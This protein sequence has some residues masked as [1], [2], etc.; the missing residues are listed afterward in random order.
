MVGTAWSGTL[1]TIVLAVKSDANERMAAQMSEYEAKRQQRMQANKAKLQQLGILLEKKAPVKRVLKRVQST[2]PPRRSAR[3]KREPP[4]HLSKAEFVK[5]EDKNTRKDPPPVRTRKPE[6]E[7]ENLD[8]MLLKKGLWISS[9]F[10]PVQPETFHDRWLH[11]QIWPKGKYPVVQGM[12]PDHAPRFPKLSGMVRW[13]NAM[14]LFVNMPQEESDQVAAWSTYDNVF[15]HQKVG[16]QS[17]VFF[18]WFAPNNMSAQAPTVLRLLQA[19]RGVPELRI[20]D[21]MEPAEDVK[22]EPTDIDGSALDQVKEEIKVEAD[23]SQTEKTHLPVYLFIRHIE[24]RC[25]EGVRTPT[26]RL[27]VSFADA[28]PLHLL[29]PFG[30]SG[31]SHAG[32]ANRVPLADAGCG[33]SAMGPNQVARPCRWRARGVCGCG[34]RSRSALRQQQVDHSIIIYCYMGSLSLRRISCAWL[35]REQRTT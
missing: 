19:Q 4:L 11:R 30:L 1:R 31:P 20:G 15:Q 8:E 25:H 34:G 12:C 32:P 5:Q 17:I 24:V 35:L 33:R 14:A 23:K 6:W 16:D 18:K 21:S 3:I 9:R 7:P 2:E 27:I 22:A 10:L 13:R 26:H 28:G 29:R